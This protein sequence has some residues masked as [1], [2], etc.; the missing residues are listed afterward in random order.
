MNPSFNVAAAPQVTSASVPG[1]SWNRVAWGAILVA[2]AGISVAFV[3]FKIFSIFQSYDD[4]GYILLSL[5]S[6]VAGKP[7]YDEVYSSFQPAF[8]VMY[9]LFFVLSGVSVCHDN[10]RFVTLVLWMLAA[11][12]NGLITRRLTGSGVLSLVVV[13]ISVRLLEPFANEPGHPQTIACVLV[14]VIVA[15]CTFTEAFAR[16]RLA[17]GLGV[18]V[19]LT[20]LTKINIGVFVALPLAILATAGNAG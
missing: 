7:L 15:C 5:K 4:E 3:Y 19:G 18:L 14:Q 10:I 1:A 16:R 12:L 8:Y 20:V 2:A 6:F 11:A 9:R 13:V 17:I